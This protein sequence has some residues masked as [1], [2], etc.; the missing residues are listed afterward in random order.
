MA[1]NYHRT[2]DVNGANWNYKTAFCQL[3]KKSDLATKYRAEVVDLKTEFQDKYITPTGNVMSYTQTALAFVIV[4]A[5]HRAPEHLETSA[6]QLI[7]LV[8]RAK[9]RI[10]HR[11]C[12]H[13]IN[14]HSTDV[15]WAASASIS[16]VTREALSFLAVPH[17]DGS[18]HDLGELEQYVT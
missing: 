10:C 1:T 6:R 14:H 16:N 5:L 13:A 3:L 4:L 8:R 17:L 15:H 7:E 9:F 12:R 18:D 2:V 11:L